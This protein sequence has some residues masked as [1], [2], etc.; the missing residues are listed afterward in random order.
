MNQ[1]NAGRNNTKQESAKKKK[2]IEEPKQE[3]PKQEELEVRDEPVS[4]S[5]KKKGAKMRKGYELEED[6]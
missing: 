5:A 2:T 4:L 6:P 3:E 1:P